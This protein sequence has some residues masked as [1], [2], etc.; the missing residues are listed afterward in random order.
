MYCKLMEE[1]LQ[2]AKDELAGKPA[3]LEHLETRVDIKVD[4]YLPENYVQ[5]SRLRM[6]MYKRIASL[7]TE[8]D[9]SDIIDEL[10]DRFGELPSVVETLLDIAQL[11]MNASRLGITQVSYRK[12]G[13]LMMKID[14]NS[15]PADEYFFDAMQ[16][17]DKRLTPS[18]K[19]PDVLLMVDP[20]LNEYG[21]LEESVKALTR[22]NRRIDE[23]MAAAQA[24]QASQ[25]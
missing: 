19:L 9:R 18:A 10:I 4:A 15:M 8:E 24:A 2:E 22:F 11:R 20:R 13:F 5:D 6:E 3:K 16:Y 17:A 21:M 14:T 23:L 12:G 25:E 1:A 7:T